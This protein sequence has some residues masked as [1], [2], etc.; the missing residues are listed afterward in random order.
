MP[1]NR[2]SILFFITKS[3]WGGA[4]RYVYDIATHL[5]KDEFA[6]AVAAA[7]GGELFSRLKDKGVRTISI[8]RFQRDIGIINDICAG[9]YVLT[10]LRKERPDIIHVNSSKAG[11]VVGVAAILARMI[12]RVR[13]TRIFTVHG[14]A[15]H[16]DRPRGQKLLIRFFSRC[17]ALC[18]HHIICVSKY[19]CLSLLQQGIAPARKLVT[20][21]NGIDPENIALLSRADARAHLGALAG[22]VFADSDVLIG[23]I[24]ELQRNKQPLLLLKTMKTL[25]PRQHM[26]AALIGEGEERAVLEKYI[27]EQGLRDSVF[28]LGNV[29]GASRFLRAFTIFA[30][31]S[32]K[33]GLPYALLEAGVA[34][35]PIV[36]S[37]AGGIP[38]IIINQENGV[39]VETRIQDS[40]TFILAF[41]SEL[42]RLAQDPLLREKYGKAILRTV[43]EKFN[44][45]TM[46]IRTT[47]IYKDSIFSFP[48]QNN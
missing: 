19:D 8:P 5:N 24:G 25:K 6:V 39:L 9:L 21:H 30:F 20:I 28:L 14:W 4:G 12:F 26:K 33:E 27:E 41:A 45:E 2:P 44:R 40:D 34:A 1:T 35:L 31:P 7:P 43:R 11:G 37:G 15:F 32:Q 13:T 46:L 38:E 47:G 23:T 36:A 42:E 16:E 17:T 18:Y 3:A 22:T 48:L 29:P 10:L